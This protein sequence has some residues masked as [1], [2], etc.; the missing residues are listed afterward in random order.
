[1][2]VTPTS[3]PS[4][5]TRSPGCSEAIVTGT[6]GAGAD[7]GA[8]TG[9]PVRA[10]PIASPPAIM[11]ELRRPPTGAPR[12]AHTAAAPRRVYRGLA[13]QP[14]RTSV[15]VSTA[16]GRLGCLRLVSRMSSGVRNATSDG[17]RFRTDRI[18]RRKLLRELERELLGRMSRRRQM[19]IAWRRRVIAGR[20][21]Q[22]VR[23]SPM[24]IPLPHEERRSS[25][26]RIA[27]ISAGE[28]PWL[29]SAKSSSIGPMRRGYSPGVIRRPSS[30]DSADPREL[31]DIVCCR[32]AR[33]CFRRR[34][35]EP[36][37]LHPP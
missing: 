1:M 15:P 27:E 17:F 5:T 11:R 28:E 20:R 9:E 14:R 36:E 35:G 21:V 22:P 18:R 6:G 26:C 19:R 24:R 37:V 16:L 3:R 23:R 2:G 30:S 34:D 13:F 32:A 8:S 12:W 25:Q 10:S 29:A 4:T 7:G 33:D 31:K